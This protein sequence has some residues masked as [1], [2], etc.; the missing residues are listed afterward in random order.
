VCLTRPAL[1]IAAAGQ[2][3]TVRLGEQSLEVD[4]RPLGPVA[5]GDWLLVHAGLAL[6]RVDAA[7]AAALLAVLSEWESAAAE[8]ARG[9]AKEEL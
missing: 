7:E 3:A 8:V 4:T 5:P 1:V 6:E 2:R 9:T